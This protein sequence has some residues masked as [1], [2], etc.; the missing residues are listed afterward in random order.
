MPAG[1]RGSSTAPHTIAPH[2]KTTANKITLE[3]RLQ[4]IQADIQAAASRSK[5]T[6]QN[7]ADLRLQVMRM[8]TAIR[9]SLNNTLNDLC[10]SQQ[11]LTTQMLNFIE[12]E[13]HRLETAEARIAAMEAKCHTT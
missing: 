9:E 13:A 10:R 7:V 1:T 11:E 6:E 4:I 8:D 12:N 5:A 3:Q 2:S